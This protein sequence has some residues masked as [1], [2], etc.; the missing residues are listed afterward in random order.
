MARLARS[1]YLLIN[2]T[3]LPLGA[4]SENVSSDSKEP[5]KV[6]VGNLGGS[7]TSVAHYIDPA[8][9]F[10]PC[11]S[12]RALFGK[13]RLADTQ[14]LQTPLKREVPYI[15]AVVFMVNTSFG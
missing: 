2:N 13:K 3:T 1:K 12:S 9:S 5:H 8:R 6:S 15:G 10:S 7:V 4:C 14:L 11:A